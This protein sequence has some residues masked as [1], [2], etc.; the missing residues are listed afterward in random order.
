MYPNIPIVTI[1]NML[2]IRG[3]KISSGFLNIMEIKLSATRSEAK[4]VKLPMMELRMLM[5]I[6]L[7]FKYKNTIDPAI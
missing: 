7:P 3:E 4:I 2:Y 6:F 1:Y 5:Y